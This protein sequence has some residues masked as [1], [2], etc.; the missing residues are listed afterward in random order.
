MELTALDRLLACTW[1]CPKTHHGCCTVLVVTASAGAAGGGAF[2]AWLGFGSLF[3]LPLVT[4]CGGQVS[5]MFVVV[6]AEWVL[7]CVSGDSLLLLGVCLRQ[8]CSQDPPWLWL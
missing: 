1:G 7:M 5:T 8:G 3:Q 2:F 4:A 6:G